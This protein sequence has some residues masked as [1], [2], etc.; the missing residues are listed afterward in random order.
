MLIKNFNYKKAI[1]WVIKS[2]S[3]NEFSKDKSVTEVTGDVAQLAESSHSMLKP[4][5]QASAPHKHTC[6]LYN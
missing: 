3:F 1:C 6:N 2:L 5:V 4:L